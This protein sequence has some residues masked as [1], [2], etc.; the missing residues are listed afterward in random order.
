VFGS[1]WPHTRYDKPGE[2]D[3]IGWMEDVVQWCL[4][5]G[6]EENGRKLVEKVFKTNAEELWFG[7]G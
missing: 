2:V 3:T 6:G 4:E 7:R 1:D 5:A